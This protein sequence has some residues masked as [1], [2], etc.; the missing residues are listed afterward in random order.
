[1]QKEGVGSEVGTGSGSV[2]QRY[3]SPDPHQN[4]TDLQH[5]YEHPNQSRWTT[6]E[7]IHKSKD[8]NKTKNAQCYVSESKRPGFFLQ[9][10]DLN[11]NG[12][13]GSGIKNH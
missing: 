9:N 2:S 11:K 1:M 7:D 10:K 4:V 8:N 13:S 12:R 5:C 3:G 6:D